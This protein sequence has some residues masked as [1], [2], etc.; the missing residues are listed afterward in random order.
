V[1]SIRG[2]EQSVPV[3]PAIQS[4]FGHFQNLNLLT[5]I[6][7]L[8]TGRTTRQAWRSSGG[9]LCP[10]A[11][12]LPSGP[13]VQDL[14][15]LAQS[16]ELGVGCDFAAR[17]L[18]AEPNAVLRFVRWWDDDALSSEKLLRQLEAMWAERLED[19]EAVQAMLLE[20]G[21]AARVEE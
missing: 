4:V 17:Q 3:S 10:V 18:G 11:H 7:D 20:V 21:N 6:E 8:R 15:E 1:G 19:A 9:L 12:G 14:C 16:S 5:L 2:K 13:L